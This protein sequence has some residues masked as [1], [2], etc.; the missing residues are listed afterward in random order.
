MKEYM[1]FRAN[2]YILVPTSLM[3]FYLRSTDTGMDL[4]TTH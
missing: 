4:G 3:S 2:M 1:Q